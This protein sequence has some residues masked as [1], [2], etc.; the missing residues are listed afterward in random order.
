MAKFV[1]K[2]CPVCGKSKFSTAIKCTDYFVSGEEFT[3]KKCTNCGFKFTDNIDDETSIGKYYQSDDYISHSNTTKGLV[4]AIYH[5]VRSYMLGQKRK[6][7]EKWTGAKTG[8][9]LDVGTGTGFFLNTM[10][11][12]GWKV[13]GTEKSPD[14]RKF[15]K[16]EFKLKV[17]DT[18]E[19]FQL[20]NESFDAITLWHVLE[21]VHRLNENLEKFNE[22]LTPNGKL[23]IAVPNYTSYDAHH[24]KEFWAAWDVPRHIWHFGPEQMKLLVEKHGLKLQQLQ[25]MPFDAFYVSML[26]EK[27]KKSKIV[28]FKG[29]I[30]GGISLWKSIFKPSNCSSLIY[31]FEKQ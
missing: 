16:K 26:S 11:T 25:T 14:A 4:N 2:Q 5:G 15:A 7:V 18:D 22:L 6:I 30:F 21:H 20:K 1:V 9:L 8:N 13:T 12:A 3:I 27:Y 31:I 17:L 19:L 29:F 28:L 23:I 10:K 24:Y